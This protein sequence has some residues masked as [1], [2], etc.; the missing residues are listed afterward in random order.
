MKKTF[1]FSPKGTLLAAVSATALAVSPVTQA[2]DFDTDVSAF[3][4]VSAYGVQNKNI[5]TQ[6]NVTDNDTGISHVLRIGLDLKD[7]ETGIALFSSVELAGERWQGNRRDYGTQVAQFNETVRSDDIRL[8]YA[9]ISLPISEYGKLNIGRQTTS[10]NNCLLVCEGRRDRVSLLQPLTPT[11]MGIINYDRNSDTESFNRIDNGDLVFFGV[12]GKVKNLDVGFLNFHWLHNYKGNVGTQPGATPTDPAHGLHALSG[13]HMISAYVGG[14]INEDVKLTTGFNYNNNG[15][16]KH[17]VHEGK[18]FN[19]RSVAAYLRAEADIENFGLG[20]Q[21]VGAID[22]GLISPGFDTYSS[23]INN[24]PDATSTPTSMYHMGGETGWRNADD[25]VIATKLDYH[26]TDKVTLTAALGNLRIKRPD[27]VNG[28]SNSD[29]SM[30]YDLQASYK[31]NPKLH[32]WATLGLLKKNKVGTLKGN[33][34]LYRKAAPANAN[35]NIFGTFANKDVVAGSLNAV[36]R[37]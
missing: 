16:V 5:N 34:H 15:R 14:N 19:K 12:V 9:Y 32:V 7:K 29:H 1:R 21:W 37:F 10:Y 23:L 4:R 24:S 30:F 3:Y 25:H 13:V 18:F 20:L 6:G 22:G 27:L 28:G 36:V 35:A 17:P 31:P 33:P 26:A 8:D 2:A 11:L